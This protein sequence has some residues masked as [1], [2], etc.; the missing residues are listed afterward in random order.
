MHFCLW[1]YPPAP[2]RRGSGAGSWGPEIE[3]KYLGSRNR[4]IYL[5]TAGVG[6]LTYRKNMWGLEYIGER[7]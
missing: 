3:E 4:E 6:F 5:V 7:F 1:E 2:R